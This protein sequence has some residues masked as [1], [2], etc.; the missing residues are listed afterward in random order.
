MRGNIQIMTPTA[1]THKPQYSEQ[2]AAQELGITVERLR[3]LIRRHIAQNEEDAPQAPV[4]T[5][6]PS[7]LL[8]LRFLSAGEAQANV[9]VHSL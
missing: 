5:F 4:T 2:E 8:V 7:D 9:P 1:K 6:Q 3:I